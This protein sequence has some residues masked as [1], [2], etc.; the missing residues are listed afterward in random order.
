MYETP[1]LE[2]FGT[3]RAMTLDRWT[4]MQSGKH[5]FQGT[6]KNALISDPALPLGNTGD[7][8]RS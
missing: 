3:F 5:P 2:K 6:G 7:G 1:K 8:P 4:A